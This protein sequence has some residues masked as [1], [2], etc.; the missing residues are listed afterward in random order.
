MCVGRDATAIAALTDDLQR[1]LHG[2]GRGGPTLYALSGID[3]ALWDIAGKAA[4]LPLYRL[5]GGS[6][7]A[8]LPAYASLLRYGSASA[9]ARYTAQALARG[10]RHVKLH[11]DTV[12]EIAAA[13]EV[14]GHGV[15]IMVDT[16]CPWTVDE[17]VA[18]ARRLAPLDLHWLEEPVWPP[19]NLAGLAEVRARGGIPTAAGENYDTAWE[20]RRA[21]EAGALGYARPSV[22]KI[23]GV[24]EMRR[25]IALAEGFGVPVVP[26][27]AYFGP[28]LLASIHCIAAM[29]S[30]TLVERFYCDFA[31]NPLGDAIH[32][33]QGRIAVPQGPGLG[34]D[35]DPRLLDAL[36]SRG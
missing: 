17:A 9:V 18:M 34:V 21:L 27:S 10:Y 16:N 26:H 3:I 14:A 28:G 8:D 22:T 31:D 33:L 25:V 23:G 29:P 35:P 1:T 5:L 19:E 15:P 32:P 11:E 4:G 20:F 2:V 24:S 30:E 36:L 13:R 6:P 7:R 12:P